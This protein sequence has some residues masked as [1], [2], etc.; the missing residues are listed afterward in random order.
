MRFEVSE[1]FDMINKAYQSGLYRLIVAYGSS[2]CFVSDTL[3][4]TKK[5][6]KKIQDVLKGDI[7]LTY[8]EKTGEE[9]WN[10]VLEPLSFDNTKRI[11][12]ITLKNGSQFKCTEDHKIFFN[13]A[14]YCAKDILS[15]VNE[16]NMETNNNTPK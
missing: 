1:T 4:K 10:K 16:R 14:W 2:R 8:N 12:A 15:L 11:I 5:G 3:V 7:V 6:D 9:Q 13:G